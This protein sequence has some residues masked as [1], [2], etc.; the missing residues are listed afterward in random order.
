MMP[1]S[2]D[3]YRVK[4]RKIQI[5]KELKELEEKIE[6]FKTGKVFVQIPS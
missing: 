2:S 1:V 3:S 6:L 4:Q 5:E